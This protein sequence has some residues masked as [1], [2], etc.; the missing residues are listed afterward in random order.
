MAGK[1]LAGFDI[2]DFPLLPGSRGSRK[3]VSEKLTVA[4]HLHAR[5]SDS[6]VGRKRVRIEDHF[7]RRL[8]P[9]DRVKH[10]LVLESAVT[11]VE[12][13]VPFL[14]R[15]AILLVIPELGDPVFQRVA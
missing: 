5:N 9:R 1:I 4:A 3:T 6:A 12:I 8:E 2:P 7:R 10:V 14:K 15:N 13:S 11:E